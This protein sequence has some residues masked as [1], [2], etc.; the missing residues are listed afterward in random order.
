MYPCTSHD[1]PDST[2]DPRSVTLHGREPIEVL[3]LPHIH[4]PYYGYIFKKEER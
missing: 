4:T 3:F 2:F 1:F